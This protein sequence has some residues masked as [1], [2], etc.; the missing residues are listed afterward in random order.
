[1]MSMGGAGDRSPTTDSLAVLPAINQG[2][3]RNSTIFHKR[4][5]KP[6]T[7]AEVYRLLESRF[8]TDRYDEG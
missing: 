2:A 7:I 5:N 6:R 4:N 3:L 8:N 1:M